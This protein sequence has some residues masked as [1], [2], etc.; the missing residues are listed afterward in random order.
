MDRLWKHLM[1]LDAKALFFG[2]VALFVVVSALVIYLSLRLAAPAAPPQSKERA[3][4]NADCRPIGV[5]GVVSNQMSADYLVVPFN[6]FR[7]GIENMLMLPPPNT[8]TNLVRRP[9]WTNLFEN[10]PPRNPRPPRAGSSGN[11]AI[12]TITFCGFF[13]RPD[14]TPAALFH[15]SASNS[16]IF[17]TPGSQIRDVSLIAAN[18]HTAQVQK[19]DGQTIDLAIGDSFTLP[20][21]KP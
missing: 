19:A 17:F 3:A 14:G 18:I 20:A 4:A 21:V 8:G 10:L 9:S 12:P 5:L 1:H 13:S 2:A 16:N 11:P 7:S 6:P 15:D